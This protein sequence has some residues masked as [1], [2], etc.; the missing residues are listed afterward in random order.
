MLDPIMGL[1][2]LNN[3]EICQPQ[4]CNL[5]RSSHMYSKNA[6]K[7]GGKVL[8]E[9]SNSTPKFPSPHFSVR[10]C[11]TR[12]YQSGYPKIGSILSQS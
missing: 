9:C 1:D 8:K 3:I 11:Y 6:L 7:S 5:H 12:I 10:F 4:K 2:I